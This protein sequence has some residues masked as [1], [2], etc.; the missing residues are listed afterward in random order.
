MNSNS[1]QPLIKRGENMTKHIYNSFRNIKYDVLN[2][3]TVH[4][5]SE[6]YRVE[7]DKKCEDFIIRCLSNNDIVGLKLESDP[8]NFYLYTAD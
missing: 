6:N 8:C 1:N 5:K 3:L 4:W 7:Y 2:S